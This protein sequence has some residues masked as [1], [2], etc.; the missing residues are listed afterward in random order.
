[1]IKT[2]WKALCPGCTSPPGLAVHLVLCARHN[3]CLG[4][5]SPKRHFVLAITGVA[6]SSLLPQ[7]LPQGQ[8]FSRPSCAAEGTLETVIPWLFCSSAG[9]EALLHGGVG[10]PS[11]CWA[12]RP[13]RGPQPHRLGW[14]AAKTNRRRYL[15][16]YRPARASGGFCTVEGIQLTL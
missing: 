6:L 12:A 3:A 7:R 4:S 16:I 14:A 8:A 1:M 11:R 5:S 2:N 10:E 9:R 15:N 13:R